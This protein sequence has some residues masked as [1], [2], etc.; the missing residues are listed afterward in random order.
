MPM[1]VSPRSLALWSV[2]FVSLAAGCG[3]DAV[4]PVNPP[5][6]AAITDTGAS[7]DVSAITD[8]G[9]PAP[10]VATV[11]DAG[12]ADAGA[13]PVMTSSCDTLRA[14]TV[15]GFMVGGLS[16]QFI[17]T[18]PTGA[19]G[20][21]GRWPVVFNWHGLG[22][23]APN[24]NQLLAGAVNNPTMPFILVTPAST[25]LGPTTVPLGIEW[26]NIQVREP[27]REA[28]L[29]DAVLRCVGERWGLDAD[30]VYTVGFSAGAI[31]SDLLGVLRGDRLAGIVSY[32]GAYFSNAPNRATLGGVGNLIQWPATPVPSRYAQLMLSGGTMDL[33]SLVVAQARFDQ[34]AAN[35]SPYLR[36]S[37]HDVIYCTHG[38]GHT[39]PP[40]VM[41]S[42]LVE[43]FAA[44]PRT[45]TASP[46][47]AG[48]PMSYPSYC[49]FQARGGS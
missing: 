43:F 41:A 15:D 34:F 42:Q 36:A 32:S 3:T 30:R 37:G 11:V 23:S 13:P 19:T 44:H 27:N 40:G 18:L 6:D 39:V 45:V 2:V 9:A 33:F 48:L 31:L 25:R 20:P 38:R 24:M 8:A 26:D 14:G 21:G 49:T 5:P 35:D 47:A 22:D 28:Q 16:R 17:L 46:W 1:T 4:T 29:F 10:D 7:T 12:V